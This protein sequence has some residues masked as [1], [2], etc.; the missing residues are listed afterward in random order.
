MAP[1]HWWEP[2][3]EI[4]ERDAQIRVN[5]NKK[6]ISI[7]IG[8]KMKNLPNIYTVSQQYHLSMNLIQ[9]LFIYY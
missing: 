6:Y 5:E 2:L 9:N 1:V 4:C 3:V 7:S 8:I